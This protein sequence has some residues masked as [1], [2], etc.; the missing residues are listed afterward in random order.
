M[1][2]E[3]VKIQCPACGK[4]NETKQWKSKQGILKGSKVIKDAFCNRWCRQHFRYLIMFNDLM[5]D[6]EK[7]WK[8][9]E[10]RR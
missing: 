10:K 5:E 3:I 6:M 8:H 7:N 1:K 4:K 9:I 2:M